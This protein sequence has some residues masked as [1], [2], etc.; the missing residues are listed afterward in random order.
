MRLQHEAATHSQ[1]ALQQDFFCGGD[2]LERVEVFKYLGQMLAYDDNDTQ[3]MQSN[4]KKSQRCW[5]RIWRVLREEN[6]TPQ[7]SGVFTKYP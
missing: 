7:V 5:A 6:A 3:A 1:Q 4:L 2:E